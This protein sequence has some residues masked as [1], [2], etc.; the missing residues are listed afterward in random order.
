MDVTGKVP[1]FDLARELRNDPGI[2]LDEHELSA[3]VHLV[4]VEPASPSQDGSSLGKDRLA[5]A[6]MSRLR[7]RPV[8]GPTPFASVFTIGKRIASRERVPIASYWTI[9]CYHV[10]E[11][12]DSCA[13]RPTIRAHLRHFGLGDVRT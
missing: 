2:P 12:R 11:T 7:K 4:L 10:A 3:M 13:C 8:H 5:S 9:L 6:R 1:R